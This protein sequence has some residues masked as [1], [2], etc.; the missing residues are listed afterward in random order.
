M[1]QEK[2]DEEFALPYLEFVL[3][4]HERKHIAHFAQKR[5]NTAGESPFQLPLAMLIL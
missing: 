4:P 5:F 3:T 1:V 2:I